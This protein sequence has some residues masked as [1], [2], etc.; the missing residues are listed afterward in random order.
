[1]AVAPTPEVVAEVGLVYARDDMPGITRRRSGGGFSYYSPNGE[2]IKN[3]R[4]LR[5]IRSLAIPPAYTHVW[6]SSL[7]NSHIQA[8]G[9]DAKGRKQYR[10]HPKWIELSSENKFSHMQA[11]GAALPKIR[12]R[13]DQDLCKHGLPREKVLATAVWF[14]EE[15]LIRVGNEEY[16]KENKSYG[17]T[18][19]RMRH[20]KVE[21]SV[22]QFKFVGKR[23][24]KHDIQVADRRMARL[25]KR[26]QD[27]PGQELFQYLDSDG[28]PRSI[29]SADVNQY[30]R[31]ITGQDFTA[32]D[33][34]TW[35][36]TVMALIELGT[37]CSFTSQSEAKRLVSSALKV[38][39]SQLGNTPAICRK[40]YVHPGVV[41]SFLDGTLLGFLGRNLLEHVADADAGE[42]A[43][44]ITLKLLKH[45]DK[46][47][48]RLAA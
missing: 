41:N 9:R 12:K 7:E 22:I 42:F 30:L 10:Y 18:T 11:F 27:L 36:A 32:K 43:E 13:V 46:V 15:S 39:A 25:V 4:I 38:V 29:S 45:L 19:M 8:T 16:A 40:S 34:R 1:M 14:L 35:S 3:Q 5:R 24:I 21:G 2:L 31:E 28:Q 33:F 44:K 37:K 6:I 48:H 23:G 17:L 20:C 47:E 26:I